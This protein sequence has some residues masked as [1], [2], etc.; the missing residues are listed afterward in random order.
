MELGLDLK[1]RSW[2]WNWSWNLRSWNWSWSWNLRSWSCSWSWYF[3]DLPELELELELKPPELELELELIFWRL[4]GVGVGVGVETSGVGVVVGVDIMELTPTL[5]MSPHNQVKY[6]FALT[7]Y[8]VVKSF[9][10]FAQSWC[11]SAEFCAT[12]SLKMIRQQKWVFWTN[13][14]SLDLI[15]HADADAKYMPFCRWHFQMHFLASFVPKGAADQT[16]NIASD[17]G[18]ALNWRQAIIKGPIMTWLT[19]A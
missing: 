15:E 9:W 11:I 19:D 17:N 12:W 8:S 4:A 14:I 5:I 10:N 6:C 16:M 13:Q 2:S 18:L 3:G 1:L 7:Y